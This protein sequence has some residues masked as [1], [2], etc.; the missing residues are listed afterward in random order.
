MISA[1]TPKRGRPAKA[2]THDDN[3]WRIVT[4]RELM[5]SGRTKAEALVQAAR[6]E[7]RAY[8]TLEK[9]YKRYWREARRYLRIEADLDLA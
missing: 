3:F 7:C 6:I 4:V 8:T 1:I 5:E 2:S 9:L